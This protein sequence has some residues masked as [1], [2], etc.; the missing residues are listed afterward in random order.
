MID[1]DRALATFDSL[2]QEFSKASVC[3]VPE[4]YESHPASWYDC[5]TL[6]GLDSRIRL[7]PCCNF[8]HLPS[9]KN[10][11]KLEKKIGKLIRMSAYI[12][13]LNVLP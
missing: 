7:T 6:N 13:F 9:E 11:Y 12:Y 3:F 10:S 4:Q 8:L 1:F 5:L 2:Y